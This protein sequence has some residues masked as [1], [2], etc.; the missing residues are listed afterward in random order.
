MSDRRC[1]LCRHWT[2]I[3]RDFGW[4]RPGDGLC[5]FWGEGRREGRDA[6]ECHAFKLLTPEPEW[7]A[8]DPLPECVPIGCTC[9]RAFADNPRCTL[10][11]IRV[12]P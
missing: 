7:R 9:R 12:V 1:G 6:S 8:G 2:K 5:G 11:G 3:A 10:H 4:R